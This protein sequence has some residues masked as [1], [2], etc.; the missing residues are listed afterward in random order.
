MAYRRPTTSI[1]RISS[2]QRVG[3][4]LDP[5][6]PTNTCNVD[7]YLDIKD[8]VPLA[9]AKFY[10]DEGQCLW[11]SAT[12]ELVL[13][14][15]FPA[16]HK[17]F[18]WKHG[19]LKDLGHGPLTVAF[20]K[21][22][23]EVCKI[24]LLGRTVIHVLSEYDLRESYVKELEV[25]FFK[26]R[27]GNNTES[28]FLKIWETIDPPGQ[29]TF[30]IP[31]AHTTNSS[32]HVEHPEFWFK[33]L[34][35]PE[36][37]SSSKTVKL[38]FRK[39]RRG[40]SGVAHDSRPSPSTHRTPTG[41][42]SSP[43]SL[44][45]RDSYS[46]DLYMPQDDPAPEEFLKR[47]DH[48]TLRFGDASLRNEYASHFHVS[49]VP[50]QVSPRD[51][52]REPSVTSAPSLRLPSPVW[53]N[54]TTS[55]D[56]RAQ[57]TPATSVGDSGNV[58]ISTNDT[59]P[60]PPEY[61]LPG[62]ARHQFDSQEGES[63]CT[64]SNSSHEEKYGSNSSRFYR[65]L[66]KGLDWIRIIAIEPGTGLHIT[67]SLETRQLMKTPEYEGLSYC[68]QKGGPMKPIDAGNLKGF[69]VSE[70]LWNALRRLRLRNRRR[71][72]W[73]DAICI[74]QDDIGERNHQITLMRRIYASALRTLIWIGDFST[75][76]PTCMRCYSNAGEEGFTLCTKTGLPALEH[77]GI[78][79]L[80]KYLIQLRQSEEG[81]KSADVWWKRLWCVQEFKYSGNT[82]TVFVGP[83]AIS[84]GHFVELFDPGNSPLTL[85]RRLEKYSDRDDHTLFSLLSMTG[86]FRCTDPRDRVFALLGMSRPAPNTIRP[87]PDYRS[88]VVEVIEDA[89]L[90]LIQEA[91]TVD[92]LLDERVDRTK[93]S[94]DFDG[95][96]MPS[97]LPDLTCLQK[98][99]ETIKGP[100]DYNAGGNQVSKVQLITKAPSGKTDAI[101]RDT[102]R[103]LIIRAIPF[104]VIVARTEEDDIPRHEESNEGWLI[105]NSL[106]RRGG[107]IDK[108]LNVLKYN[109]EDHQARAKAMH[110][111]P[112]PFLGR[113]MLDYLFEDKR[114]IFEEHDRRA[115][116][117]RR[118][119]VMTYRRQEKEDL[120]FLKKVGSS[121][122]QKF[123]KK[124][125]H[126]KI[127]NAHNRDIFRPVRLRTALDMKDETILTDFNVARDVGNLFAYAR[128]TRDRYYYSTKTFD[129]PMRKDALRKR[130]IDEVRQ[131]PTQFSAP[132]DDIDSIEIH[133]YNEKSRERDFFKTAAE[134]IG[135][136][137]S[138]L[139][140][141][142]EVIVPIGSSRPWI[143]RKT[144]GLGDVTYRFIGEAVIPMIMSE[145]WAQV[146]AESAKDY[147]IK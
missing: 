105:Y 5:G 113:L 49:H 120:A 40:S 75:D 51:T 96:F 80:K 130:T 39:R 7:I 19:A 37:V 12:D 62:P 20:T 23:K 118:D 70:H 43:R 11:Y 45:K 78:G 115:R 79:D 14:H 100:N 145:G 47:F 54:A 136:G 63:S 1:S 106:H 93:R 144:P 97:W 48:A 15:L 38:E 146:A 129:P 123:V 25:D 84:W 64:L 135:L 30:T 85:F 98:R 110:L 58:S 95:E 13:E 141:G 103:T 142:D 131:L 44:L 121:L 101:E 18:P 34:L 6:R 60:Q 76:S 52:P 133:E 72:V 10:L 104:D 28:Q 73:V 143:V 68:W 33:W 66:P 21:A 132:D 87:E 26:P 108:I 8:H 83:H 112:A 127:E 90:Y 117:Y 4:P 57:D 67:C 32:K 31:Y 125:W 59:T 9:A 140:V 77:G 55:P 46:S 22:D 102:A 138:S 124:R 147:Y 2:Q 36:R 99:R 111:P 29:W 50:H 3:T 65:T 126:T 137:T 17:I 91:G 16:H 128:H 92:V 119:E 89:C 61:R 88:T 35:K 134:F 24:R 69:E 116:G 81:R 27:E 107:V 114:S 139:A 56:T 94:V 122:D 71:L 42:F 41:L 53:T 82:P 109:F 74:N 86:H